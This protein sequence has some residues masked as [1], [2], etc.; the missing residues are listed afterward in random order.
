MFNSYKYSSG[1]YNIEP[2]SSSTNVTINVSILNIISAVLVPTITAVK[3]V[4]ISANLLSILS[5]V[6]APSISTGST[7]SVSIRTLS[8]SILA[9][10]INTDSTI[11]PSVLNLASAILNPS[12]STTRN[13]TF[14]A[15]VLNIISSVLAPTLQLSAIITPSVLSIS[16]KSHDQGGNDS[17]TLL[18]MHYDQANN[19]TT[20]VDSS[21]SPKTGTYNSCVNST[22]QAKFLSGSLFSNGAAQYIDVNDNNSFH[23]GTSDF[24]FD[25]QLYITALPLSGNLYGLFSHNISSNSHVRCELNSSGRV[26]YRYVVGGG[27]TFTLQGGSLSANTWNHIAIVKNGSSWYLFVNGS[28]VD[29][30][31]FALTYPSYTTMWIGRIRDESSDS[32]Y[33]TGYIDEFRVSNTAR[34]TSTFTIPTRYYDD[35]M[36][37]CDTVNT[38]NA[39]A[40]LSSILVPSLVTTS[41]VI[42]TPLVLNIT[43]SILA[44]Q[45][46]TN[47][48]VSLG[49]LSI[50]SSVLSATVVTNQDI[51]Y[52]TVLLHI[53]SSILSPSLSLGSVLNPSILSIQANQLAPTILAVSNIT[54]TP[55]I[56]NIISA[57]IVPS[58]SGA[59]VITPNFLI[60]ISSISQSSVSGGSL[61]NINNLAISSSIR[62]P[63]IRLDFVNHVGILNIIATV[64]NP[65]SGNLFNVVVPVTALDIL[66]SVLSPRIDSEVLSIIFRILRIKIAEYVINKTRINKYLNNNIR[67]RQYTKNRINIAG[68]GVK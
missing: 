29:N 35:F 36:A 60:I 10:S 13:F 30:Q 68:S 62:N 67:I 23:F 2:I 57:I 25:F 66:A 41:N 22:A 63:V 44:P 50:V 42:I 43:S 56:L 33:L 19:S 53:T 47:C 8:S 46:I 1:K 65:S 48:I 20:F 54:L 7:I 49:I 34:W 21:S 58:F 61:V 28:Q 17:N 59:V 4:T 38:S 18:L 64:Y 39:L 40:I 37:K 6:L 12:V 11:V 9:P 45:L 55:N 14:S 3:N 27:N 52:S 51:V 15:S 31:A 26:F 5:A 16:V 24:T 32:S